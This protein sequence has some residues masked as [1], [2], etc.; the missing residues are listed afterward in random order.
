MPTQI[1]SS[2]LA[3]QGDRTSETSSDVPGASKMDVYRF[4]GASPGSTSVE[5]SLKRSFGTAPPA[6]VLH[7]TINV[8]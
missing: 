6:R 1:D 7:V 4:A 2:V 8:R 5:M 3:Q